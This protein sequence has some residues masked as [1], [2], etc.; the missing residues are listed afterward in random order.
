MKIKI[1]FLVLLIFQLFFSNISARDYIII[2]STTSTENSGL[3]DQIEKNFESI[4]PIDIRVVS[5][6][7]GQAIINAKNGDADILFVHSEEDEIKFVK[8][9]YGLERF[10]V[11]YN[12]FVIL[13]P[14]HDPEKLKK[15]KNIKEALQKLKLGNTPFLSRNDDSGTNKKEVF[16]WKFADIKITNEDKWYLKNGLG[17]GITLNMAS[18]IGA[19]TISDRATWLS[20]KNKKFLDIVFE[21]DE[22]LY[23]PY[24]I[25]LVN[26]DKY[27][28][29]EY[30]NSKIFIDW[31]LSEEGKLVINNYRLSG[32][33]LFFT[34]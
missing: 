5:V 3:L 28:Y 11:M 14:K 29:V 19:Y 32:Q 34:F 15:S 31:L 16:L 30:N 26:P 24:G 7:T 2:Q 1:L 23:N 20:F 6:G 27:P 4:Y 9:G 10:E 22:K 21:K 25:V 33:Q 12:D 17:M 18:E 8:E 13:G